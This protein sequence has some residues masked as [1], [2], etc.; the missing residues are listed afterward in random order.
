M[1]Q[2]K[3]KMALP[4]G[5]AGLVQN[6]QGVTNVNNE[7]APEQESRGEAPVQQPVSAPVAPAAAQP[8]PQ[9]VVA[10]PVYEAP[11]PTAVAPQQPVKELVPAGQGTPVDQVLELAAEYK[12]NKAHQSVILVD[13]VMKAFLERIKSNPEVRVSTKD[14]ISAIVRDFAER[15]KEELNARFGTNL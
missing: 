10:Q 12:R 3:K 14:I 4:M 15:N 7:P 8:A 13:D 11:Q 5:L 9:P 1:P 2:K 6:A